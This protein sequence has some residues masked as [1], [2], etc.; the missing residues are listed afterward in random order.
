MSSVLFGS[1]SAQQTNNETLTMQ[2]KCF[3]SLLMTFR[4]GSKRFPAFC[5]CTSEYWDC[6]CCSIRFVVFLLSHAAK[7]SSLSALSLLLW[8]NH[9]FGR[10]HR[11]NW[12]HIPSLKL[13]AN[14]VSLPSKSIFPLLH[15]H[16]IQDVLKTLS[17]VTIS[18]L[19]TLLH[20]QT[21]WQLWDFVLFLLY[22]SQTAKN[23]FSVELL[24]IQSPNFR[25]ME[26]NKH[27]DK[28]SKFPG[29]L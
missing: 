26:L 7:L 11:V 25:T 10:L 4:V 6:S 21:F 20:P 3:D 22:W 14:Y 16:L 13:N 15:L 27:T 8:C 23:E 9:L 29:W 18:H 24:F 1:N 28:I 12:S 2:L 19:L 5:A 17:K